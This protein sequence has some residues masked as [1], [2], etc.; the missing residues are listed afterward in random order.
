MT[1]ELV[2]GQNH[3]LDRTRVEIRITAGGPVVAGVTLGDEQGRLPGAEAVAHPGAPRRTG[4]EVPRQA[5]AEHRLAVD[6]DAL[7]EAVHRVSVLLA[8]PTGIG[9]LT[10]FG[11]AAAPSVA[12]TGLDGTHLADYT[13]TGLGAESAVVAVELYRRQGAWKVRAVG[14]GYADGLTAMLR[15][16]GL[17]QAA[18]LA[19]QIEQAVSLGHARAVPAPA[20]A[21]ASRSERPE[22]SAAGPA[23]AP[24]AQRPAPAPPTAADDL[25]A[26][27]PGTA[28]PGTTGAGSGAAPKA[29]GSPAS[30]GPVD[31]R[32]PARRSAPAPTGP[33]PA[34]PAA[35]DGPPLPVAGDAA[36]WS[37]EERLYNQVWGMFEDL[38]RSV[39]AYRSAS[40]FA[41]S[42]LEQELDR[43]LAD[44]R[45]RLGTAADVARAT[46]RDKHA[47]L[48]TQAR[49][50]LDRDLGQLAAE[51]EV[52]EPALP[53]AF[54][55]WDNP[56]WQGYHVPLERPMALRLG[57]LHLP[58]VLDLRIPMLVRLP[59]ERGLW[60]DSGPDAY[61]RGGSLPERE[62]G[63]REL[64]SALTDGPPDEAEL[65]RLATETAVAIAARLLAVHPV[66]EFAVQVIDPGGTAAPALAPLLESG[67]LAP[68]LSGAKG[69][70]A[71]LEGLTR[72]VDLVQMA[73][74]SRAADALP[75]DLDT[76][77]QLLIVHDFPHG[78]DD[79]ALTQLRYLADEGPAVGVHLMMVADRAQAREY[80]PVLDPLW[81]SLLRITPVPDAHLADPWVGHAWTYEPPLA[82]RGSQVVRQVLDRLAQ[83]RGGGHG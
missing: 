81:R 58:E 64:G 55:R 8:L 62:Y 77:E 79:R 23:A 10:T 6:L 22:R 48:V 38:A 17:A 15:D 56:V 4:I 72:R 26:P 45:N 21:A 3:P 32:H 19:A 54:A 35:P 24:T 41:E 2:R 31:Y 50:A 67:V 9:A 39:A 78:F 68:P 37:M 47:T 25:A 33:A 57:D 27:G 76:A 13:I 82:P 80:G 28:G 1:A 11:A 46:A 52:V 36:G 5:A 83:A 18:E 73:V 30:R 43:A 66:G 34:A 59:L 49:A 20:P 42:R 16:Q 44:P 29:A 69:V 70:S 71:V 51:S 63:R 75:P 14:Q 40:D 60:I 12:V 65:R 61:D 74:R 7:P 53:P